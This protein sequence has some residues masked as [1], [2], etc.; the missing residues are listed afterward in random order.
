MYIPSSLYTTAYQS[1]VSRARASPDC[2]TFLLVSPDVDALCA[3][4]ALA[5]LFK[6]DDVVARIHPISGWEQLHEMR[7]ELEGKDVGPMQLQR[8]SSTLR[9]V[10]LRWSRAGV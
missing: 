2:T 6:Q 8:R 5:F 7:R 1:I 9:R 10:D 4:R 3:A